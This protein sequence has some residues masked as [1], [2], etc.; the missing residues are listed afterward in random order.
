MARQINAAAAT[1]GARPDLLDVGSGY[2]YL[3]EWLPN[4]AQH[5]VRTGMADFVGLGR[6]VLSY[7]DMAADVLAGRP[8]AAQAHLPHLQRLHHRAAQRPGLRLLSAG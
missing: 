2:S 1:Q 7:P 5:V 4:V 3:Q 8:L 6:M